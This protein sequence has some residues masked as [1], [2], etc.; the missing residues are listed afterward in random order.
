MFTSYPIQL[1]YSIINFEYWKVGIIIKKHTVRFLNLQIGLKA[2]NV[3][4]SR[5][6]NRQRHCIFREVIGMESSLFLWFLYTLM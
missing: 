4:K 6:N 1:F 2:Q 3:N 5:N